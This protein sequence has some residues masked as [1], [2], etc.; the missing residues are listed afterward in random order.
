MIHG[1]MVAAAATGLKDPEVEYCE[2]LTDKFNAAVG[3]AISGSYKVVPPPPAPPVPLP[4]VVDGPDPVG[5]VGVEVGIFCNHS[6]TKFVE[7]HL[8][9]LTLGLTET[10]TVEL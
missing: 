2:L 1:L 5:G 4:P 9:V 8:V 7:L 3:S 6:S 10:T